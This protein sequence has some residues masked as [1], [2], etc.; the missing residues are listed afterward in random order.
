MKKI[1]L[2]LLL[3]IFPALGPLFPVSFAF[4]EGMETSGFPFPYQTIWYGGIVPFEEPIIKNYPAMKVYDIIFWFIIAL[5]INVIY[6][7]I[8]AKKNNK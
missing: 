5:I 8:L 4:S 1:L 2:L 3:I 7:K 6:W